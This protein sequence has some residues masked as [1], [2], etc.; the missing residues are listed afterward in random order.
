MKIR[1]WSAGLR[2]ILVVTPFVFDA[3]AAWCREPGKKYGAWSWGTRSC[4][5]ER[6]LQT[7]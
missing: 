3:D 4:C 5:C 1:V 2:A 6:E 7:P